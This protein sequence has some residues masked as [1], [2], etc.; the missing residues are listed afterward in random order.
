MLAGGHQTRNKRQDRWCIGVR[1]LD[2]PQRSRDD[3]HH[4]DHGPANAADQE[5]QRMD[6]AIDPVA[7]VKTVIRRLRKA[8]PKR[9]RNHIVP[10][11]S[12]VSD[13]FYHGSTYSREICRRFGF[14]PY[15]TWS[16]E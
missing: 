4:L 15:E 7:L 8:K 6:S 2:G 12:R 5:Q 13:V 9:M 11:W 16:E 1:L 14:N 3:E 10:L